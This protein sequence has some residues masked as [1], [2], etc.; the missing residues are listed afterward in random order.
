[1]LIKGGGMRVELDKVEVRT[2]AKALVNKELGIFKR[3]KARMLG[4]A[5]SEAEWGARHDTEFNFNLKMLQK[6]ITKF[7]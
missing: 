6:S 1:M 4:E 7:K 3:L 5:S 2:S